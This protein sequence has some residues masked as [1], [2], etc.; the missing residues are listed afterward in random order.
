MVGDVH[1][2]HDYLDR[3]VAFFESRSVDLIACTGDI[4]DGVGSV[5]ACCE[6]LEAKHVAV[7]RGNH[8]RW[9]LTGQARGLP[10]ATAPESI[11]SRSRSFLEHLPVTLEFPTIGGRALLCHGLGANDMSKV[12][13]DDYGYA[14]DSNTELQRILS[15]Q[16]YRWILNGHSHRTMVRHIGH[17]T[18]INA[19][20]LLRNQSPCILEVD[21]GSNAATV[22]HFDTEG[23][24]GGSVDVVPL[25]DGENTA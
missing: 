24:L 18:I 14:L 8:D 17:I 3:A 4:A 9:L 11:T 10:N 25:A 12:G 16:G 5:D 21:F 22:F 13:P 1:A 2:Q 20:T 19:G 23:A 6:L 15:G 7:V